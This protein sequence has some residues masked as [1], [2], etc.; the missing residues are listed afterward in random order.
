M[1]HPYSQYKE[2]KPGHR[3]AKE[4]AKHFKRG[5]E[6]R[7]DAK[8][9]AGMVNKMVSAHAAEHAEMKSHGKMARGGRLD[10]R[11]RGG[12]TKK[13][14]KGHHTKINIMVAPKGGADAGAPPPDLG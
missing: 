2:I 11:A 12:G 14:S 7:S 5:G 13:H 6:V 3:R 1:T 8:E 10:K 4:M 9:D